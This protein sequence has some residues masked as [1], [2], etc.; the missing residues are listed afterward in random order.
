MLDSVE[1]VEVLPNAPE[2]IESLTRK[3]EHE[4]IAHELSK[5]S[6]LEDYQA[7]AKKYNEYCEEDR[8]GEN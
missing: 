1:T 7:V 6:T 4:R 8:K 5:C 3:L 2:I